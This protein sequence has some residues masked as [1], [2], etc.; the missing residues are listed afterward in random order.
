[1]CGE[2]NQHDYRLTPWAECDWHSTQPW[3][4]NLMTKIRKA[5]AMLHDVKLGQ[6]PLRYHAR[7][8]TQAVLTATRCC[9]IMQSS[10]KSPCKLGLRFFLLPVTASYCLTRDFPLDGKLANKTLYIQ[11]VKKHEWLM[12]WKMPC[13]IFLLSVGIKP[14]PHVRRGQW[15]PPL[16]TQWMIIFEPNFTHPMVH[17]NHSAPHLNPAYCVLFILKWI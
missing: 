3:H 15:L 10:K 9:Q 16:L 14:N 2:P 8:P 7:Y 5:T 6:N 1:M 11:L 12:P 4:N 17:R 13:E